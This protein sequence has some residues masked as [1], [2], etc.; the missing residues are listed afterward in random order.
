MGRRRRSAERGSPFGLVRFEEIAD[1][2]GPEL[3][4]KQPRGRGGLWRVD[5]A[6]EAPKYDCDCIGDASFVVGITE[7][8][9]TSTLFML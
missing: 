8:R 1:E 2:L 6:K 9:T 3:F 7:E 5:F 4:E